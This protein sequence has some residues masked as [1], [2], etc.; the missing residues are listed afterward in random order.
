M[1]GVSH[2]AV[3]SWLISA[4]QVFL[5]ASAVNSNGTVV[6]RIGSAAV[7]M[8]A[9]AAG[10]PVIICCETYKFSSK[11]LFSLV[12]PAIPTEAQHVPDF[13]CQYGP[14]CQHMAGLSK[15]AV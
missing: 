4:S 8:M 10:V 6:S 9:D 14:T 13:H 2:V 5:G 7:A 3:Q 1:G 15:A 12:T 11:V